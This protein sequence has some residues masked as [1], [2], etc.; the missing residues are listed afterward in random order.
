MKNIW[1]IGNF[2][3]FNVYMGDEDIYP[4]GYYTLFG[5]ITGLNDD[6]ASVY[7]IGGENDAMIGETRMVPI[8]DLREHLFVQHDNAFWVCESVED[9]HKLIEDVMD[10]YKRFHGQCSEQ[11]LVSSCLESLFAK[12]EEK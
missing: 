3:E 12:V 2:V 9:M 11:M 5:A 1:K 4:K 10:Y 8:N 7:I 6:E